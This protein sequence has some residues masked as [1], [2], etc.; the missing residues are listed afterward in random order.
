MA[1]QYRLPGAGESVLEL[2]NA[3]N[4]SREGSIHVPEVVAPQICLN[5]R[6]WKNIVTDI[7]ST[8]ASHP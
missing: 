5:G 2:K 7:V 1:L 6:H 4:L 8:A 3:A